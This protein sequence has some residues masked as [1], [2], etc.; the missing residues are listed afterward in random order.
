MATT[1]LLQ[2]AMRK[3]VNRRMKL[4]ILDLF[5][6]YCLAVIDLLLSD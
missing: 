1:L 4:N 3:T 6:S 5:M 2:A